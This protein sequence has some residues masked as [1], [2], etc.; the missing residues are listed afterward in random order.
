MDSE[1]ANRLGISRE[2]A[3][4]IPQL[5]AEEA[6][7]TFGLAV[8]ALE[9]VVA[10]SEPDP[11]PQPEPEPQPDPNPEPDPD[12]A[13]DEEQVDEYPQDGTVADVLDW[14]GDDPE[15]AQAALDAEE[16]RS[17]PRVTL[18]DQ[19]ETIIEEEQ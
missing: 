8:S 15:L 11:Q 1:L 7:Q 3:V 19:L 16:D 6:A 10:P 5:G 18:I 13:A 2:E 12:P 9:G 14:V 17:K 4:L